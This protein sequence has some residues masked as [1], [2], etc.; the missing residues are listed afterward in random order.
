MKVSILVPVY[1]VEKYIAECA[2]SL[3]SQTYGE[4]EYIFCDDCTP[5]GSME[6]LRGVME[7]HPERKEHVTLLRNESNS[8]LGYTRKRLTEALQTDYFMIV[9]SDD[10][11]PLDA[12]EKLVEGMKKNDTDVVSGA[13]CEFANGKKGKTKMP[14][15]RSREDF[16]RLLL[17]QNVIS[18]P[19]WGRLFKAKVLSD[20]KDLF[21]KG[22]D[23]SE[24]FCA[25]ARL[26]AVAS[27]S[28]IDDEVYCYRTDNI[29]SYTNNIKEK[30]LLSYLRASRGVLDFYHQRGHLPMSLEI[31]LIAAYRLCRRHGFPTQKADDILEYV[32][33]HF[34][35]QILLSMFRSK[36]I[37]LFLADR[38]YRIKRLLTCL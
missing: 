19:V 26:C 33:E 18:N 27:F 6:V 15:K 13:Y 36:S 17:C 5:D 16:Q 25:M 8:G 34:S 35:A 32:P 4:I 1:G 29:S 11:L 31:G 24:D 21:L 22:I 30:D 10:K 14:A 9:D 3:F 7:K 12:V 23:Y 2:E 38:L 37:P 20:V 28:S